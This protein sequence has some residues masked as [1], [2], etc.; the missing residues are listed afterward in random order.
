MSEALNSS[1]TL[2]FQDLQ[3]HIN[4][5]II[6]QPHLTQRLLI[7]LLSD[8]HLLVEGPPGL[9]KT[10]AIKVLSTLL[11]GVFHRIQFTPDLLPS[12]ITGT[13]IYRPETG[14]FE[15]QAGPIFHN[16]ILADEINRAPAKVQ[17]A[18][19]E[20]MGEG[21]VSVGQRSLPMEKFFMVMATQNPLDQ[22]GTYPLPEAQLDRFMM[23]VNIDYP[24]AE[25]ELKILELV[26]NE[27][28]ETVTKS[29]EPMSQADLFAAREAI[30]NIH[31]ADTIKTYIV[32]LV[33]ATRQ[34]EKYS[35]DL[36]SLIAIGVS[37]RATIALSRCARAHAW[38]QGKD[39]VSPD[40]VQAVIHDIFRH[41]L[42]LNFEAEAQNISPDQVINQILSLVPVT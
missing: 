21:Q 30:L 12:D 2:R 15:F 3:A 16:L 35:G 17:A 29:F 32:E 25:S 8:G 13:D 28:R 42:L 33:M 20:A 36:A 11:E 9:A 34:P 18:L 38:L 31:V 4:Q 19:L 41:R 40:D 7:T 23:H 5:H 22:E 1:L 37:P 26:E 14:A 24:D 6:G 27:A 39:F 10:K